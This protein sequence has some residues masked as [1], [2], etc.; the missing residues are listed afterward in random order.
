MSARK[1][2]TA[3]KTTKT[4]KAT[5]PATKPA[6][7]T[8]A[9][10]KPRTRKPLEQHPMHLHVMTRH[11]R[12]YLTYWCGIRGCTYCE[13]WDKTARTFLP[14]GAPK[15]VVP[16]RKREP[17]VTAVALPGFELATEAVTA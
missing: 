2:S 13:K 5:K 8:P 15:A 16:A 12:D 9:P 7:K 3:T 11:S 6:T 1:S 14:Y 4:T 10:R 17:A